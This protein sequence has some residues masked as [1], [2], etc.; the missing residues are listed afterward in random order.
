MRV[1]YFLLA[2]AFS[3]P[4]YAQKNSISVYDL[5]TE[6]KYNPLGIDTK[7]P[8]FSWKLSS[9]LTDVRQSSYEIRISN[10]GKSISTG[11]LNSEQSHLVAYNGEELKPLTR[12]TWQ[13]RVWDNKSN[14]SPWS[15]PSYF[16]TGLMDTEWPASWIEPEKN[17]SDKTSLPPVYTRKEFNVSKKVASAQLIVTSRG[18]YRFYLNGKPVTD[19]LF[20]PGWTS[21]NKRLQYQVYDITA[22]LLK[23][24]NA[25]GVILSEG[26]Y[27][28]TLG[29]GENRNLYG[30]KLGLLAT[31]RITY[32]DG[33]T[34]LVNSDSSWK[35]TDQGPIRFS[36]IYDGEVFDANMELNGW[37]SVGFNDSGWWNVALSG[38]QKQI[39]VAN[40]GEAVRRV[41][42]VKPVK[43][44]RTPKGEQV[45]DMGQNM[46]GWMRIR[47]SGSKGNVVK[48]YHAE[49][50]DKDGNFYT[51][52]L[53]DAKALLQYTCN[54]TGAEI[55][56]PH[57]TFMGFRYIRIEG[58][59]GELKPE[60]FTG[61]VIHSDMKA[62]GSLETSNSSLNQLQHNIQWGQKGNFLDVPTDC[63]Q[64]DE[65][66]GWTGDAQA[67]VRTAS[68]NYDIAS[69]F[70]KWL[71]DIAADQAT[72]GAVPFVIPD[73]LRGGGVSAGW[74]DVA[75][76]APMTIYSCYGDK[77]LLTEQY[78]SM[79]KY[80]DY[81][82][83][84][85]G[86][87]MIWKGGSVFGDWLYY[88]PGEFDHTVSDGHTD[89]DLIATAFYAYSTTLLVR[90]AE[91]LG[92][93]DD[94]AFYTGLLQ[95][96]KDAYN[97]EYVSPSGRVFSGSQTSYVLSL[98]FDLLPEQQRPAAATFLVSDIKSRGNHLST[99]FLGTPYL[100][101]VLSRFGY[102]SVAYD[103]LFQ[104]TYPSWLYPV[105]MGATTIWERWDGMR[106]DKTFQDVGM[107]SFNHY[108]Y[109]AIGEWMYTR[110]AGIDTDPVSPGY[111][112]FFLRPVPTA[113]LDS[114]A[115]VYESPYG[116]IHSSWKKESNNYQYRFRIPANSSATIVLTY[117]TNETLMI[118]GKKAESNMYTVEA[119]K[120]KLELGSGEYMITMSH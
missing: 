8:R 49:V 17:F 77:Q 90:A 1:I 106:P 38:N 100:C 55:F 73:V 86:D 9:T 26:W 91:I 31:I 36:G 115:A 114:C 87:S 56:E 18:L 105:K 10:K 60:D 34:E 72:D 84:K 111:K 96:I 59:P 53:R 117:H 97:R 30:K 116:K 13:V 24:K 28:G 120:V 80:V 52:N 41:E 74:G 118:N 16:E 88:H 29:W 112:H 63:P 109:G 98:M 20:T 92:K 51:E 70:T 95:K 107:N 46:V 75:V 33:S 12:Y 64:R 15:S 110:M 102:D 27:R 83:N 2:I 119:D 21:Y 78:A 47:V 81:I 66:L 19:D 82:R 108:A 11:K 65:R 101:H 57:F 68:Y 104:D 7:Q 93:D 48:V 39:I 42:E 69:F 62:T 45:L 3:I 76:I 50:L 6:Y 25:A 43:I 23:G 113:K 89:R 32:S 40:D 58:I 22:Q 103:L 14:A 54:G 79:K 94:K 85:S 37:T 5:R 35:A 71:K 99:G 44:F 4:I 67:F 61:I